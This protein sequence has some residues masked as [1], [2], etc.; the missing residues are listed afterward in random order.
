MKFAKGVMMAMIV[1]GGVCAYAGENDHWD[2][3]ANAGISAAGLK[4][5]VKDGNGDTMTMK[6]AAGGFHT[7]YQAIN[8]ENGFGFILDADAMVLGTDEI[9]SED[10]FGGYFSTFAGAGFSPIHNGNVFLLLTG[11]FGFD[12]YGFHIDHNGNDYAVAGANLLAGADVSLSVK[13]SK[14][15]GIG[16]NVLGTVS[17]CGVT[18]YDYNPSNKRYRR[19]R[20]ETYNTKG[21]SLSIIPSVGVTVHF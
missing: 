4:F 18:H 8:K 3:I 12:G 11:G 15:V 7:S 5:K 6:A 19:D 13:V 14:M 21:G 17:F 16:F 20:T 1:L 9:N 2:K 10:E